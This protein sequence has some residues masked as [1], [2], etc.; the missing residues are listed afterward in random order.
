MTL[1]EA[2]VVSVSVVGSSEGDEGQKSGESGELH[3]DDDKK[4]RYVDECKKRWV[5]G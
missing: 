2:G 3:G 4:E 5:S 1:C